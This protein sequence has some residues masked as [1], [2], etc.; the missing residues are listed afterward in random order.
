MRSMLNDVLETEADVTIVDMEAGLEHLSRS[1]GTLAYADV[2]LVVMEPSRKS[3]LT[4]ARTIALADELGITTCVAIGNKALPDDVQF[5]TDACGE[6]G[7]E[8]IAVIPFDDA[9]SV[10]DRR[11][12]S[13][14]HAAADDA[15]SAVESLVDRLEAVDLARHK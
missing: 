6:Y 4:A 7:V 14:V 1:G 2:L 9:V 12:I 10:A 5:F 11:G 15:R 13:V 8:M 3:V